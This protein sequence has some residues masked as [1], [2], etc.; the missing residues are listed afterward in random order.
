MEEAEIC[1]N[2]ES[3]VSMC[4]QV[5]VSLAFDIISSDK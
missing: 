2:S 4:K 5:I 3:R 1:K